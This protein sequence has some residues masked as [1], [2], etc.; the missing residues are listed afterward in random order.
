MSIESKYISN[1]FLYLR[2]LREG[3]VYSRQAEIHYL[4]QSLVIP[5][6]TDG[7]PSVL[8]RAYPGGTLLYKLDGYVPPHRIGFLG[9][10]VGLE[11]GM[12]IIIS[13]FS[14]F[15]I[16]IIISIIFEHHR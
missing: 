8:C 4:F 3:G 1:V 7:L 16:I 11:L 2:S 12:A 6:L 14:N 15:K 13:L 5:N 10:F 9:R